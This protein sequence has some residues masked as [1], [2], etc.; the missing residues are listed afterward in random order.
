MWYKSQYIMG[1]FCS[2]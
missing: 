2:P 1:S